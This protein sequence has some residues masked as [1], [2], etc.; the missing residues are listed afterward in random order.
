MI[1]TSLFQL[2]QC[3]DTSILDEFEAIRNW[4]RLNKMQLKVK[5]TKEV[6]LHRPNP[7]FSLPDPLPRIEHVNGLCYRCFPQCQSQ[8]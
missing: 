5:K 1:P 8:I 6:V 2:P 4:T 3:S 7:R